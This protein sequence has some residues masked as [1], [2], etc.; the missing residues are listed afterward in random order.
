MTKSS[1]FCDVGQSSPQRDR[2]FVFLA[3]LALVAGAAC[4][5][6]GEINPQG[7]GQSG[8]KGGNAGNQGGNKGGAGGGG[9]G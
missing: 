8:N 3:A 5:S 9:G 2:G 4:S 7:G 6:G 1:H